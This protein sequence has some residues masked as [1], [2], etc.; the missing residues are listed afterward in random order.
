MSLLTTCV[1]EDRAHHVSCEHAEYFIQ[2]QSDPHLAHGQQLA[3]V[4][5]GDNALEAFL[6]ASVDVMTH[7]LMLV[8]SHVLY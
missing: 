1:K 3:G 2:G 4:V 6:R 5:L 8:E 7:I